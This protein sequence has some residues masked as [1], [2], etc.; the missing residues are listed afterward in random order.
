MKRS[1]VNKI[2]SLSKSSTESP[3]ASRKKLSLLSFADDED[4]FQPIPTKKKPLKNPSSLLSQITPP[5]S[6]PPPTSYSSES[7][8]LLKQQ[9]PKKPPPS[10]PPE[11]QEEES[12]HIPTAKEIYLLKKQ[13]AAALSTPQQSEIKLEKETPKITESLFLQKELDDEIE[14]DPQSVDNDE[15]ELSQLK[16]TGMVLPSVDL[17]DEEYRDDYVI[18]ID[19]PIPTFPSFNT[20]LYTLK[21]HHSQKLNHLDTLNQITTAHPEKITKLKQN[22]AKIAKKYEFY[23]NLRGYVEDLESLASEKQS[24][25]ESLEVTFIEIL[26][27]RDGR[28]GKIADFGE[29]VKRLFA[30]TRKEFFVD[31]LVLEKFTEWRDA[32]PTGFE[33]AHGPVLCRSVFE[34]VLRRKKLEFTDNLPILPTQMLSTV[35]QELQSLGIYNDIISISLTQ[36]YVKIISEC[37]DF[38]DVNWNQWVGQLCLCLENTGGLKKVFR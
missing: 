35:E 6:D 25:L 12:F 29:D 22:Q 20:Y 37:L 18:P 1:G 7:L 3:P 13:R 30:D 33:N 27:S 9:Q 23:M 5:E 26:L 10:I 28:Q 21:T 36:H 38:W 16:K 15:F 2:K 34:W 19:T 4:A 14:D 31:Q 8:T 11:Q 24:D 17:D 32:D